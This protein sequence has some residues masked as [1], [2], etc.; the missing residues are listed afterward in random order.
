MRKPITKVGHYTTWQGDLTCAVVGNFVDEEFFADVPDIDIKEHCQIIAKETKQDLDNLAKLYESHNV[1]VYRPKIL[2]N[3]PCI[4]KHGATQILNPR[5]NMSPFDHIFCRDN[6]IVLTWCDIDRFEDADTIQHILD[7]CAWPVEIIKFNPPA[8]Y[9]QEYY[10]TLDSKDWPG[11][12]DVILDSPTFSPAGKHI[13]YSE[14]YVC[15]TKGL[16]KFKSIFPTAKFVPMGLPVSNH[17][18]AQFRIIKEGHVITCHSAETLTA[19]CPQFANWEISTDDS[20]QQTKKALSA[21]DNLMTA[22]L[23]TD[24]SDSSIHLGFVHVNPS[25]VIT[26]RENYNLCKALEKAKVDWIVSPMRHDYYFGLAISC[27]T[28]IIHRSDE[29]IDYFV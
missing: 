22:W 10:N 1:N 20:W 7:D 5:P 29:N 25:L 26:Q 23:D 11:N 8:E 17:L 27:A 13:F 24:T 28:A 9:D 6:K 19:L 15:S 16:E 12:K 3:K 21:R 18:D 2:N 4:K 14:K